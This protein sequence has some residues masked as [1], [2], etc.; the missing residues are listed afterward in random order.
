MLNSKIF[1]HI[2]SYNLSKEHLFKDFRN[3][4]IQIQKE[5]FVGDFPTWSVP[6]AT[7][8]FTIDKQAIFN[9]SFS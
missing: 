7:G 1:R 5:N 4:F 3:Q 6:N 2:S 9:S 8:V